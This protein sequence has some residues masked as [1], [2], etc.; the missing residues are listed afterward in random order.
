MELKLK[1]ILLNNK[2]TVVFTFI[3]WALSMLLGHQV[4]SVFD[5]TVLRLIALLYRANGGYR[6]ELFLRATLYIQTPKSINAFNV[7][8]ALVLAG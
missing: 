6:R 7:S 8:C 5:Y 3:T 2:I 1:P 4:I